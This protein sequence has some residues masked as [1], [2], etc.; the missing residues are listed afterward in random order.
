[1]SEKELADKWAEAHGEKLPRLLHDQGVTREQVMHDGVRTERFKAL[2]EWEGEEVVYDESARFVPLVSQEYVLDLKGVELAARVQH[3]L[4]F[5][6][7]AQRDLLWY[8]YIEHQ[9]WT[10]LRNGEE[11]RQT[12]HERLAWARKAFERAWLEHAEDDIDI[13]EEDF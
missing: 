3:V 9:E 4:S 6:T 10:D 12:F 7:E 13:G 11:K 2:G 5:L 1:M 8:Y